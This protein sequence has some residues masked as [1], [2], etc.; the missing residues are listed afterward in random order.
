MPKVLAL[1]SNKGFE[2]FFTPEDFFE[3]MGAAGTFFLGACERRVKTNE[4]G[5]RQRLFETIDQAAESSTS[6]TLRRGFGVGEGKAPDRP[7]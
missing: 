7:G 5:G 6:S 4:K 1:V 3:E 2:F